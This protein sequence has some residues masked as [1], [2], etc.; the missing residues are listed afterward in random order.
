MT[1]IVNRGFRDQH[2]MDMPVLTD[3]RLLAIMRVL[4]L[5]CPPA[6]FASSTLLPLIMLRMVRLSL[7]HGNSPGSA[8]AYSIYGMLHALVLGNP[9]RATQLAVA[10][11]SG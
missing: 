9:Q 6:Y 1:R 5:L 10:R 3:P 7:K 4:V 11:R 8:Y 2:I